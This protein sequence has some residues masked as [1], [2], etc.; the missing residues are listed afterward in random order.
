MVSKWNAAHKTWQGLIL[1]LTFLL[2]P[3][4][5]LSGQG[6]RYLQPADG[7][8][9]SEVNTIAQDREG[10][11]WLGTETGIISYD[12]LDFSY[13]RPELGNPG[14]LPDRR[15]R[16][17]LVDSHNNLWVATN[18]NLSRYIRAADS[19]LTY[20]SGEKQE[21][22]AGIVSLVQ[23]GENLIVH[24]T[25]GLYLIPF[26]KK[27][28]PGHQ[29]L[30]IAIFRS[31]QPATHQYCRIF[32][33]DDKLYLIDN[34]TQPGSALIL[35]A[36]LEP[37]ITPRLDLQ[38]LAELENLRASFMEYS[39]ARNMLYIATSKGVHLYSPLENRILSP[40]LFSDRDILNLKY[41]STHRLYLSCATTELLYV[42][43]NSGKTGSHVPDPYLRGSL[44]NNKIMC[45]FEDFSGNLLA[46]H[47]GQGVSILNLYPKEFHTIK[48]DP[49]DKNSL[50]SGNVS[51]IGGNRDFIFLGLRGGGISYIH[52]SSPDNGPVARGAA[53]LKKNN[54]LAD[55][56][57]TVW[58]ITE[59]A[60][61][62]FWVGS[63]IG[64]LEM[65]R[66]SD[67]WVLEQFSDEYLLNSPVRTVLADDNNNI[68]CGVI[69][70]G[71][72]LIPDPATNTGKTYYRFVSDAAD[73]ESL[74]DNTIT[75]MTVDSKGRF[76]LGTLNGLNLL[77][78]SIHDIHLTENTRPAL[79]F[80]RFI[81][82]SK[83]GD[84][85]NNNEINFIYE[86]FDGK[87]WF[88]TQGGGINI[89]DT[90]NGKFTHIT[91]ENGLPANDVTGILP[92]ET[93]NLWI[94]TKMGLVVY[95]QHAGDPSLLYYCREDGLHNDRFTAGSCY[96]S[97]GGE[98]FFGGED[99]LTRFFPGHIRPNQIEPKLVFT[100]LNF[101]NEPAGIGET[102]L[103]R[104]IL[105]QH[106]NE[107][108]KIVLPHN[109]RLFSIGAAAVHYQYPRGN[110]IRY[111]LHGYDEEW[112]IIPG[113]YRNIYYS[114]LPPGN[115]ILEAQ[116]VNSNNISSSESRLISIRVLKPWY[117]MW[118]FLLLMT[119]LALCLTGGLIF[120]FLNRQKMI[121]E[122]NI[123]KLRIE[124]SE[125]KMTLLTDIA[126]GI[127]TPLSLVIAPIDDLVRSNA[128]LNPGIGDRLLLI[129]RNA[130]YLTKLTNQ[131][132]DFSRIPSGKLKPVKKPTDIVQLIRNVILNFSC[133]EQSTSVKIVTEIPVESFFIDID[134]QKIEEVLY[135]ILSNAFKHTPDNQSITISFDISGQGTYSGTG[136]FNHAI[137]T[138]FNEGE[139]VPEEYKEKI[140]E[141]FYKLNERAE[142]AGIGLSFAKSLVEMHGG[143]IAVNPLAGRGTEFHIIL[144]YGKL[145][146]KAGNKAAE[147]RWSD[148]S[149]L[150]A[151][152]GGDSKISELTQQNLKI[153][154]VEDNAEL[155]NFLKSVLSRN[156]KCYEASDG[157]EGL[158]LINRI[159][160]DMVISDVIMPGKDGYQ[161]CRELK[162][163]TRTC[164]IPVI[165][166]TAK[167]SRENI[168]SGYETGADAYISK[169]FD[170]KVISSQISRLIK[171]RELIRK[172]YQEQNFM[173][174][175]TPASS[176]DDAFLQSFTVL[177]E[178]NLA[179]PD[180][181]V[182]TMADS[183]NVSA[184]QLYRKIRAL[185]GHS[186][187][188][189]I[190]ILKLNK[191]YELLRDRKNSVKEVCYQSGFNNISYF[192]KCFRNHFGVTPA[193]FKEN[194]HFETEPAGRKGT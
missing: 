153:V 124:N 113:F 88:A 141:R 54:Q 46:G 125:N 87:I 161:L 38:G 167:S 69:D 168:I 10:I 189:F 146:E 166:L 56:K 28:D 86:N 33:F 148:N 3:G 23:H 16:A 126:H 21:G 134:P 71:L 60:G 187:V 193:H 105:D 5:Y 145:N 194:G 140:F 76:W 147:A 40:V 30:R 14:S 119:A 111:M 44:I 58:D 142:G 158:R 29:P 98:M 155:R 131:I 174:E 15:V 64:L 62:R 79:K 162:E 122:R 118:Y 157:V 8:Y 2:P 130:R 9:G 82:R 72:L 61:S 83:T 4:G 78:G 85:L 112:R 129:Q 137:I 114:N 6:F 65:Y 43:M 182:K 39:A 100:R 47:Q 138:V 101:G 31:G 55:F 109:H 20:R 178:Q 121:Y 132:I 172:K 190:K 73:Q 26:E 50:S 179:N 181:N 96:K 68:W 127:K 35:Q 36:M 24:T 160:P 117:L 183:M 144:P 163:N 7:L 81:A 75:A 59:A 173:V 123:D 156:Y 52:N 25:D 191:S 99:G 186:P 143:T 149:C 154:L 185:T 45:L 91:N 51:A 97:P 41:T 102:V 188:E 170:L 49:L 116:A 139:P 11:L 135:N 152:P 53:K 89:L 18:K 164:H 136:N 84:F 74:S 66:E 32:S 70:E 184:T 169:P 1:F 17:M 67:T 128:E 159:I 171:N 106:I 12:G 80:E 103:G 92:D 150:P 110:R 27:D 13:Y 63:E 151:V 77:E 95:R 42:D 19:F 107:T 37:G 180:F 57:H 48:H 133:L 165:L 177:L 94:S 120:I 192:I 90:E 34:E 108:G 175:T 115:Y 176:R 22:L 104:K 93:G